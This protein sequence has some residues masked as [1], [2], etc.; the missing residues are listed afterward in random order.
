MSFV[1]DGLL[2]Y[3]CIICAGSLI[4]IVQRLRRYG[5]VGDLWQCVCDHCGAT[6][7]VCDSNLPLIN[8]V[9]LRGRSR[10]CHLRIA[11]THPLWEVGVGVGLFVAWK[12][13][14][15]SLSVP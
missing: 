11:L 4:T 7:F 10:C 9:W 6:L 12:M 5:R 2:L 8:Y 14:L 3:W 13:Y 1:R 15:A